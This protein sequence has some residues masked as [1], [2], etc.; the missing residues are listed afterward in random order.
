[1]PII[2][3]REEENENLASAAMIA[4]ARNSRYFEKLKK[5]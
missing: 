3:G 5:G 1:L 4:F 2:L